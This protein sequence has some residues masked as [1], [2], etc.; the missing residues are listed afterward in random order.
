MNNLK[1]HI[2]F[3]ANQLQTKEQNN[4]LKLESGTGGDQRRRNSNQ[5]GRWQEKFGSRRDQELAQG[6]LKTKKQMKE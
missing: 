5:R 2:K 4:S 6:K 1:K 3:L